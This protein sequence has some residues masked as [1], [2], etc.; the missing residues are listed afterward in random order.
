MDER[1][2]GYQSPEQVLKD[3]LI[4]DSDFGDND[5]LKKLYQMYDGSWDIASQRDIKSL[6]LEVLSSTLGTPNLVP[7]QRCLAAL[8][9]WLD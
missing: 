4:G 5:R 8:K 6:R 3:L 2:L 9:T 7:H 1:E